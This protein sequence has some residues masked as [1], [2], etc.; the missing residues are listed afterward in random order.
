MGEE[1]CENESERERRERERESC[2][3]A[4]VRGKERE[5]EREGGNAE[6][7]NRAPILYAVFRAGVPRLTLLPNFCD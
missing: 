4:R 6:E 2:V 7:K 1:D 5:R 3:H